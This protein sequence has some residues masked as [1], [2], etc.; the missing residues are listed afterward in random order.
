MGQ[1]CHIRA[2]GESEDA[3]GAVGFKDE[4]AQIGFNHNIPKAKVDL[5]AGVNFSTLDVPTGTSGVDDI[6]TVVVGTKLKFD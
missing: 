3:P 4:G 2:Y 6:Y 1:Q 5:Y